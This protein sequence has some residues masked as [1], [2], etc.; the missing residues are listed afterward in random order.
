MCAGFWVLY[1]GVT[2]YSFVC[3][4]AYVAELENPPS[5]TLEENQQDGQVKAESTIAEES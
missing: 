4:K 3:I 2:I 5:T 1:A